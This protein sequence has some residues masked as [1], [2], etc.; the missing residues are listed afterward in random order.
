MRCGSFGRSLEAGLHTSLAQPKTWFGNSF[1]RSGP[2]CRDTVWSCCSSA[3]LADVRGSREWQHPP[4]RPHDQQASH[5]ASARCPRNGD[6]ITPAVPP[7]A[8]LRGGTHTLGQTFPTVVLQGGACNQTAVPPATAVLGGGGRNQA[9]ISAA[10]AVVG[11]GAR[12]QA[13]ALVSRGLGGQRAQPA[14]CLFAN[15]G[16]RGRLRL[17]APPPLGSGGSV[18]C[19]SSDIQRCQRLIDW[20]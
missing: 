17:V 10:T 6:T 12:N 19:S 2:Q 4:V 16:P 3:S 15:G 9:V 1:C 5:Y 7:Q 18:Q 8:V 20:T 13:A 11:G 14:G